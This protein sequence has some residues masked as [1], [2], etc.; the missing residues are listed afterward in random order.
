[1]DDTA[2]NETNL[3]KIDAGLDEVDNRVLTLNITKLDVSTA[4]TMVNSIS[5]DENTGIFT[6]TRLNGSTY[7]IDTKLEKLAINFSYDAQNERLVITLD[8]GTVQYVDMK[9]LITQY[10]FLDSDVIAFAVRADGK[11]S[12]SI[13]SGS[14]T[15]SMLQPNYLAD[16][17]VQAGIA[18]TAAQNAAGSAAAALVS[19]QN[20]SDSEIGAAG[21]AA[22]ATAAA[23][24]ADQSKTIAIQQATNAAASAT[25]AAASEANAAQ[26]AADADDAAVGA[27]DLVSQVEDMIARGSFVGPPGPQGTKGDKGDTGATGAQGP[28]GATGATGATGAQ[29]IQGPQG[30][31]GIQG[32]KGDKGDKGDPGENGIIAPVAGFFTMTVDADGNLYACSANG[33]TLPEFEYDSTTGNL[34][35]LTDETED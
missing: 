33:D 5:F 19:E 26:S 18:T 11:V 20:A 17:T 2:L 13:K 34:Y 7:T 32:E 9:A 21:S 24:S 10:E 25:N 29:G 16:I 4:N 30:I 22:T 6:I 35:V 12:A 31:Q 23:Q 15:G 14:I 3:N 1:L 28:A 8:D 27:A